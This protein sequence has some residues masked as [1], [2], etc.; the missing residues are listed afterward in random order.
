MKLLGERLR[1]QGACRGLDIRAATFVSRFSGFEMKDRMLRQIE[2]VLAGERAKNQS[3]QR[4]QGSAAGV[5]GTGGKGT[6]LLGRWGG[7]IG[8]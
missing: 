5:K 8:S 7:Q 6:R 1:K 3:R 2:E 4:R